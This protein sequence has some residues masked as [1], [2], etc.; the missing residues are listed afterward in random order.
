[1]EIHWEYTDNHFKGIVGRTPVQCKTADK[2]SL[3]CLL[4]DL[5]GTT[6]FSHSKW[7]EELICWINILFLHRLPVIPLECSAVKM[8]AL[9]LPPL[10]SQFVFSQLRFEYE[11]RPRQKLS[12]RTGEIRSRDWDRHISDLTRARLLLKLF[13]LETQRIKHGF[14]RTQFL[15]ASAQHLQDRCNSTIQSASRELHD[16]LSD[17]AEAHLSGDKIFMT[18]SRFS[19][20]LI[21]EVHGLAMAINT[22]ISLSH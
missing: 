6:L 15:L 3:S 5:H 2:A 17:T 16:L 4:T 14:F 10:I 9:L 7:C 21:I 8:L 1:M 11:E 13:E 19:K 22:T 20:K 12:S 18:N